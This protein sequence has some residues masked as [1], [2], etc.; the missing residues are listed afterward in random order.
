[1]NRSSLHRKF[2][3]CFRFL[4]FGSE[5]FGALLPRRAA[6]AVYLRGVVACSFDHSEITLRK[7]SVYFEGLFD[8]AHVCFLD[9]VDLFAEQPGPQNNLVS[10]L[11]CACDMT[12]AA[13][14]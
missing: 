7:A 2:V 9:V 3:F 5:Q 13:N 12:Q 8:I 6:R 4:A 10:L 11:C 1:M 14:P